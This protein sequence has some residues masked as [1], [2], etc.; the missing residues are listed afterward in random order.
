LEDCTL[1]G[2]RT[3]S[4]DGGGAM[5]Y[6]GGTL[7]NCTLVGNAAGDDGGGVQGGDADVPGGSVQSCVIVGNTAT[8][9]GGGV[10]LW[11]GAVAENCLIISNAAP[12]GGGY[13]S[14]NGGLL[15]NG[16][17]CGNA[18]TAAGGGLYTRN[19]GMTRNSILYFNTG[20]GG[21]NYAH[22]AG[23]SPHTYDHVCAEPAV[24]DLYSIAADPRFADAEGQDW[25][26][27]PDSPC[28]D[29]GTAPA[30]AADLAGV[31]R[32]LDGDGDASALPDLGAY[33][34][35]RPESDSDGDGLPDGWELARGLSPV[36]AAGDDGGEGDPD[37]DGARN[38]DEYAADTDPED[39]G[40]RLAVIGLRLDAGTPRLRWK[41]GVESWQFVETSPDLASTSLPWRPL[42][43]GSPPTS[44]TNEWL[45]SE[46]GAPRFYRI[47]ARRAPF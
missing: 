29:A 46:H 3:L 36:R 17:V 25:T 32:P 10:F 22:Y 23:E 33:E 42:H 19:G 40:S 27:R 1:A 9:K 14:R 34:F 12:Y 15:Q 28:I 45:D 20:P 30:P 2:N 5:L 7:R 11:A 31:P 13:S 21:S 43:T 38:L 16:T 4:D 8:D 26:L 41:G 44:V 47:R 6:G 37:G 39:P 18:A 24:P 35:L